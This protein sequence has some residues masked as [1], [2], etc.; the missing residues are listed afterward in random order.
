MKVTAKFRKLK[1][2]VGSQEK[3]KVQPNRNEKNWKRRNSGAATGGNNM[4]E[5]SGWNKQKTPD[6]PADVGWNSSAWLLGDPQQRAADQ[7]WFSQ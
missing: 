6:H 4:N 7:K 2:H 5:A 3:K 1:V